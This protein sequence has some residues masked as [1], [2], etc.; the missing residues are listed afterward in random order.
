MREEMGFEEVLA[1][2][3]AAIRAKGGEMLYQDF[4]DTLPP[5]VQLALPRYF[6]QMRVDGVLELQVRHDGA[7]KKT[8][9]YISVS[10][11]GGG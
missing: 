8:E 1:A 9:L 6:A 5:A 3:I 7:A 10:Q 11:S 2:A 4:Q